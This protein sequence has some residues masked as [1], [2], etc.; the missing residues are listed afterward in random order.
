VSL[1]RITKSSIRTFLIQCLLDVLRYDLNS[2]TSFGIL[3][4]NDTSDDATCQPSLQIRRLIQV[5]VYRTDG[6]RLRLA[7]DRSPERNADFQGFCFLRDDC[8]SVYMYPSGLH[9]IGFRSPSSRPPFNQLWL[10]C[11]T[12]SLMDPAELPG[13]QWSAS[14]GAYTALHTEVL[15]CFGRPGRNIIASCGGYIMQEL[16]V[17]A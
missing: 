13:S 12:D 11:V 10:S 15:Q 9:H 3:T 4:C 16:I 1:Y 8:T 14:R 5:Y 7:M 2:P 17:R 6:P